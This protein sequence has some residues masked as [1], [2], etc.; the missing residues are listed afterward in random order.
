MNIDHPGTSA[1]RSTL[2]AMGSMA[3]SAWE[4]MV[5]IPLQVAAAG[6]Q[7]MTSGAPR[8]GQ[9]AA[10]SM[11]AEQAG[12]TGQNSWTDWANPANWV[13]GLSHA[14]QDLSGSDLKYVVWSIVFTKPGYEAVLEPM[15]SELINYSPD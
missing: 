1:T 8:I 4:L 13:A 2:D 5:R 12:I 14:N 11:H 7:W 6:V 15:Q 10:P 3:A 9:A